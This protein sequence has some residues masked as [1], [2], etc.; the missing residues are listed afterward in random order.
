MRYMFGYA[1]AFNQDIS[2]WDVSAV[3]DM[4]G[5]FSYA[6]A[7]NQDISAWDVSAATDMSRLFERALR[8]NRD[9]SAWD[10]ST[11]T[12]MY[13]MFVGAAAFSR[14]LC[15]DAWRA[16]RDKG[17]SFNLGVLNAAGVYLDSWSC[18]A[19]ARGGLPPEAC[20]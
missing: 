17:I 13:K 8:F 11:A 5:L 2:A 9:I 3:T 1:S 16:S 19:G 20:L 12:T 14:L 6:S 10:V 4:S 18:V 7:F 15:S